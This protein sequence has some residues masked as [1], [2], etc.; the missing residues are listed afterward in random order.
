[1]SSK[2]IALITGANKGIG[3]AIARQLGERGHAV[4]LGCRDADRGES[5]AGILRAAGI[6][7]RALVLDVT[8]G[9]AVE[10]AER[11]IERDEGRLDVLV[12]N[13]GIHFGP[14]PPAA[15]ES[16]EDIRRIFE[17]NVFGA[18]RVTQA[19]LPLLR[20]SDA[21]RI[22][23]VSSGL[24]SIGETLDMR[25]ENW[26]VGFAGYCASKAALNMLVV[27]LAKELDPHGIKVNAADPGLTSTDL[28]GNGP[29]H[30]PDIGARSAVA[31]AM[32]GPF[33]QTAAFQACTPA[34]ELVGH[35]W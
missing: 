6:E 12:N 19:F 5:A 29:G 18:L 22:V 30:A 34:G 10:E 13:A 26:G 9:D 8:V 1:M 4:I 25:S 3:F 24:G 31:L 11:S 20:K 28:T 14:P 17:T 35:A 16:I 15:E 21:G 23:M 2:R 7:A 32:I 27:K 33:G